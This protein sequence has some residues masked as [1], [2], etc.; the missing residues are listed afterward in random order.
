MRA[1]TFRAFTICHAF[2][3]TGIVP[4]DL[5]VVL[6]EIRKKQARLPGVPCTSFLPPL[7]L[8]QRTP[9]GPDLVVKY[10]EKLKKALVKSRP[11]AVIAPV[12]LQQ[13]IR[14]SIANALKL[15]LVD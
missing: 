12:Q 10:G 4:F 5:E 11:N 8:N 7:L 6:E 3:I 15:Q 1:Q 14:G 2:K 13:F 9:Q